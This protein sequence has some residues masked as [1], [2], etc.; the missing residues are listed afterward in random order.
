MTMSQS[1]TVGHIMKG[2]KHTGLEKFEEMT[3]KKFKF[4]ITEHEIRK[5]S[6]IMNDELVSRGKF[7]K[8]GRVSFSGSAGLFFLKSFHSK[9]DFNRFFIRAAK[10]SDDFIKICGQ[11]PEKS[12]F[13]SFLRSLE[14][15]ESF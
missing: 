8:C 13:S 11:R 3:W 2:G 10:K 5:L 14:V 6:L 7:Q 15:F 12:H 1:K 4:L 9:I